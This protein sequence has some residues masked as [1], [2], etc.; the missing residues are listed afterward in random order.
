VFVV[1]PAGFLV[2]VMCTLMGQKMPDMLL[3]CYK[4]KNHVWLRKHGYNSPGSC[5]GL[6]SKI[7]FMPYELDPTSIEFREQPKSL[8]TKVLCLGNDGTWLP[9]SD[10]RKRALADGV[11]AEALNELEDAAAAENI[12]PS[13]GIIELVINHH[14]K[15]GSTGLDAR[16]HSLQLAR[17]AA[18]KAT[19]AKAKQAAVEECEKQKDA[20]RE[21]LLAYKEPEAAE[22]F[23]IIYGGLF[24]KYKPIGILFMAA[25]GL[26]KLLSMVI[27]AV[28]VGGQQLFYHGML[29][30]GA[31]GTACPP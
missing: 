29:T 1:Y 4:K 18:A 31:R 22:G 10:L 12:N 16:Q 15:I 6:G 27:M 25:D 23:L 20:L 9:V 2:A 13:D 14:E 24:T 21:E 30:Q 28:L 8:L 5:Y 3:P 17:A 11:T 7:G 26:K 19:D